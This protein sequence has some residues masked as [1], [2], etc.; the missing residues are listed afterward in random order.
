MGKDGPSWR[1]FSVLL[2]CGS[3]DIYSKATAAV[4][5]GARDGVIEVLTEGGVATPRDRGLFKIVEKSAPADVKKAISQE[6]AAGLVE[7][8]KAK[9]K[10]LGRVSLR[11]VL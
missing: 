3:D 10:M 4:L 1:S 2:L 11:H 6:R 7:K 8:K 5:A 9:Q